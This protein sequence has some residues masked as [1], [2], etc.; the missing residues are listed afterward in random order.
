MKQTL[1]ILFAIAAS[2]SALL[3]AQESDRQRPQGARRGG[4]MFNNSP[5]FKALGITKEGDIAVPSEDADAATKAA[6]ADK[7]IACDTNKDGKLSRTE[8]FGEFRRRGG[9]GDRRGDQR[10]SAE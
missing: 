5:L 1:L 4:G 6:F 8:M 9:G 2:G 7:I 10:P 3:I